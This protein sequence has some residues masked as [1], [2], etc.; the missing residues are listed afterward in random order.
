MQEKIKGN[1]FLH[2][3]IILIFS[4]G[5]SKILGFIYTL[6]LVNR[7]GFGDGGNAIYAGSYQIYALLLT[8][9]SIGVPNAISKMVS[10]KVAI[11]D[12]KSAYRNFKIALLTFTLI[13]LVGT[14]I[15]YLNA[16]II[17]SKLIEIPESAITLKIL[18]PAILFVSMGSVFKGY[19]N[20]M[21]NMEATAKSQIVE[22][23]TK[24]IFTILIVEIIA[25]I[26]KISTQ[27]MVAGATIA[28]AFSTF[29]GFFYLIY[30][31][32]KCKRKI[33][34]QV[35]NSVNFEYERVSKIIKNILL[36]S[37]PIALSSIMASLTKNIDSITVV[38][39]LRNFL[40]LS[41]AKV[42]Y[43]ILSGKVETLV[44]FP[45][46][47]NI[48]FSTALVPAISTA[49]A[50]GNV[51][52]MQ[53]KISISI[54]IGILIGIPCTIIMNVYAKQILNLLFPNA[55]AGIEIL[56][57]S[58]ISIVFIILTQTISGALQGL[59]KEFVPAKAYGIG[60][61]VKII[62]NITLIKIPSIGIKGAAIGTV[63]CNVIAFLICYISLKKI[64]NIKLKPYKLIILIQSIMKINRRQQYQ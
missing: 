58:S 48:A 59:G 1:S 8:L 18:S 2:G 33:G 37:V 47:F 6:Y 17:A 50:K 26:S 54:F 41:E 11:G 45:L 12:W 40:S 5:F 42:Q 25:K 43:G 31:Y 7:E 27:Y 3:V 64:S 51:K 22:Q 10:Q 49:N 20:G 35:Y 30:Y 55:N 63:L 19:F 28:T 21:E 36:V 57:I 14:L 23:I 34:N 13:G 32:N 56:K 46:S 24:T 39:E 29:L 16:N 9:S 4:Q 62:C 38:R 52:D 15:L 60:I 61:I 53:D 44:A